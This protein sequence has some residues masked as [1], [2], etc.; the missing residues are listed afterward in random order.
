VPVLKSIVYQGLV[1][2]LRQALSPI[3]AQIEG[4]NTAAAEKYALIV[5]P[6]HKQ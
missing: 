1:L 2:F 3:A 6:A 5:R 4:A